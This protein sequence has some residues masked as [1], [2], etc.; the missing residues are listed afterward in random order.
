[1]PNNRRDAHVELRI[2]QPQSDNKQCDGR[3]FWLCAK[4]L[5]NYILYMQLLM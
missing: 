5:V 4:L 1:M 3:L 2:K